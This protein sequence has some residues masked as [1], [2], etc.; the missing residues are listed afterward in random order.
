MCAKGA[1]RVAWEPH[2]SSAKT[3]SRDPELSKEARVTYAMSIAYSYI[4][5]T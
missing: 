2:K 4:F 1:K 3:P 5:I